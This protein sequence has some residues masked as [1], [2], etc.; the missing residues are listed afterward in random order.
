MS[1]FFTPV[2]KILLPSATVTGGQVTAQ[3]PAQ[4]DFDGFGTSLSKRYSV[5]P[6]P[7]TT[8]GFSAPARPALSA[9]HFRATAFGTVLGVPSAP[10]AVSPES[11]GALF[12]FGVPDTKATFA[13]CS[14]VAW[15]WPSPS[16]ALDDP[17]VRAGPSSCAPQPVSTTVTAAASA[18]RGSTFLSDMKSSSNGSVR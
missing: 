3:S 7:L 5:S 8:T 16:T 17:A 14:L 2:K 15:P 18:V 1:A 13:T 12:A 11:A 6:A 10:V 4:L 9:T